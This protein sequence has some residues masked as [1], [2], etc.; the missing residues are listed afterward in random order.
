MQRKQKPRNIF[1]EY[2]TETN[3][4]RNRIYK[5]MVSSVKNNF[6]LKELGELSDLQSEVKQI[7]QEEILGKQDFQYE[8]KDLFHWITKAVMKME[9][10]RKG[11]SKATTAAIENAN[12]YLPS[13]TDTLPN[14]Q[15]TFKR[16]LDKLEKQ[17][18]K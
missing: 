9:E 5:K 17:G 16:Q 4:F 18:G 13:S 14:T 2:V 6:Q 1:S 8:T 15:K 11:E 7:R 12:N 10:K 3:P